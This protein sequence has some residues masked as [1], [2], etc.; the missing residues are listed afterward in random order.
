VVFDQLIPAAAGRGGHGGSIAAVVLEF[1]GRGISAIQTAIYWARTF[2]KERRSPA[3]ITG[4]AFAHQ[5][6]TGW[7]LNFWI[8]VSLPFAR[9]I[10]IEQT[11]L[12]F[13]KQ[14]LDVRNVG[15]ILYDDNDHGVL[16][17]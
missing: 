14:P 13:G 9:L 3:S 15:S 17:E 16:R 2:A 7:E 6:L 1:T 12:C 4:S 5:D 10:V 8:V 11:H